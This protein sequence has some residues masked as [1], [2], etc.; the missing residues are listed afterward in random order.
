MGELLKQRMMKRFFKCRILVLCA[1]LSVAAGCLKKSD[2]E[3]EAVKTYLSVMH[4]AP[5]A[6]A[7]EMYINNYRETNVLE[8]GTSFDY[9]V[10]FV[11]GSLEMKFKK[12]SS[13]SVMAVVPASHYDSLKFY[14]I[15]LYNDPA[16]PGKVKAVKVND[17]FSALK[18]DKAT[19]RFFNMNPDLPA[20]NFYIGNELVSPN[21]TNA[22]ISSNGQ[23]TGF[24]SFAPGDYTLKAKLAGND[25][26]IAQASVKFTAR[27]AYTIFLQGVSNG[28]GAKALKLVS[29]RATN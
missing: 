26:L 19:Y 14:T 15:I 17:D 8:P 6:P 20:V 18:S 27:N 29:L 5:N 24:Q 13:D 21:R 12:A 28:T 2:L 1:F 16:N 4:L 23:L 9:Y 22:D 7:T 11:P 10:G 3:P 25:S